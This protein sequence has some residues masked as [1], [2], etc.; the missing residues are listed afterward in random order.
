MGDLFCIII[1]VITYGIVS[2]IMMGIGISQLKSK[3]PV[4]FYSGEKPPK[5][6]EIADVQTWNRKHGIMWLVYG[7]II[8]LSMVIGCLMG[9]SLLCLIPLC[10]GITV[11]LVFMIW[12]HHKLV[13]MYRK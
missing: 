3:T 1:S 6:S 9:D 7:I 4:G 13:R 11:P 2:L 10:G 12:Y 8:M 5:E